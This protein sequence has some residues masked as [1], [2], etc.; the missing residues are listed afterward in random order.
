MLNLKVH[1]FF[2]FLL[3]TAGAGK[4]RN[5]FIDAVPVLFSEL[6]LEAPD[7]LSMTRLGPQ[8]AT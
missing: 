3:L 5:T 8:W 4:G 2:L 6:G 1:N 7:D